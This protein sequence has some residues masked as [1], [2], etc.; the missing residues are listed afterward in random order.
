VDP[1]GAVV[2]AAK[3]LTE[4]KSI[5]PKAS[6]SKKQSPKVAPKTQPQRIHRLTVKVSEVHS[7]KI[8]GPT[9]A[10]ASKGQATARIQLRKAQAPAKVQVPR[11]KA[12]AKVRAPKIKAPTKVQ[13]PK[14]KAPAKVLVPAI[15]DPGKIV[16]SSV[17]GGE[18][19]RRVQVGTST[20]VQRATGEAR[21]AARATVTTVRTVGA[22]PALPETQ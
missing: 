13:V 21:D 18:T 14:V 15:A 6:T 16:G 8:Q 19:V 9:K 11:I 10:R 22:R 4:P 3:A 12:P 17:R 7:P 20:L 2:G 1:V 5:I